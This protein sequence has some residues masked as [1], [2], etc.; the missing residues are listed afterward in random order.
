VWLSDES[1][2]VEFRPEARR[3]SPINDEV[4]D[5][6]FAVKQRFDQHC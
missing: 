6:V 3:G 2:L 5:R 1:Y 4:I